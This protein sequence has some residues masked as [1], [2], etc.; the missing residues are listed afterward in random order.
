MTVDVAAEERLALFC[1]TLGIAAPSRLFDQDGAPSGEL[2]RFCVE[3]GA[4]LDFIVL[5][6][7]RPLIRNAYAGAR[8]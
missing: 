6:D 3:T 8:R 4:S 2:V 1:D 5:G 7:V